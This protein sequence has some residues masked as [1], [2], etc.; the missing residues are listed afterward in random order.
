MKRILFALAATVFACSCMTPKSSRK[1]DDAVPAFFPPEKVANYERD[2]V[3]A[4]PGGVD[5]TLDVSWPE[6]DGPFPVLLWIHG[7]GWEMFSKEANEG[8]ARYI[9][10]RGYVVFNA[11]YRMAP[12]V[13]MKTIVEDA[14]GV[15]IWVKDH[16]A[17]YHGDPERFAVSGHSAGGHLCAMVAVACG[18]DFFDPTYKSAEGNDC[19]VDLSIPVSGVY[20]FIARGKEDPERW[21]PIFGATYSEDPGLY[22]KC[23][24][25]SY[26][27]PGLA[28]TLVVY[29][30]EEDLRAANEDWIRRLNEAGVPVESHMQPGVDHLWPTWHWKKPAQESYD[31]MVRFLDENL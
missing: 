4:S 24:P 11:N 29:A 2:V 7:G 3:W 27:R 9:A 18:D 1:L 13:E 17:E 12:E 6:G 30:E 5:L 31:R 23:S 20:D 22:E 14:L 25:I 21:G 19:S 15:T 26:V 10:N 8:L 16:A 28:P